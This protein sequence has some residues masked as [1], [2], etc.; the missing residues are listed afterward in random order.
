MIKGINN[1]PKYTYNIIGTLFNISQEAARR[2]SLKGEKYIKNG[3]LSKAGHPTLLNETQV[4]EVI[5]ATTRQENIN[6]PF[7]RQDFLKYILDTFNISPSDQWI[8]SFMKQNNNRLEQTNAYS[9]EDSRAELTR[10]QLKY[11]MKE[12]EEFIEDVHPQLLINIDESGLDQ[13][14]NNEVKKVIVT[15]SEHKKKGFTEVLEMQD[16]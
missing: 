9:L 11:H 2:Y 13:I 6:E 1:E 5:E 8:N 7:S 15:K 16:I 12:L 14:R 4:N 3:K 10:D